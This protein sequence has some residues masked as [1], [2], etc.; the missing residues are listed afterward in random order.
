MSTP[1]ILAVLAL[2][3]PQAEGAG[4]AGA[5]EPRW[6]E[7]GEAPAAL[8]KDYRP[9]LVLYAPESAGAGKRGD[10][11]Q[12][13]LA[14]VARD[15]TLRKH[16]SGFACV[17]LPEA[18]LSKEYPAAPGPAAAAAPAPPAPP[19]AK[20]SVAKRLGLVPGVPALLVIDFREKV[21]RRYESK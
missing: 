17:K 12:G 13:A 20:T 11:P 15:V 19:P 7:L 2:G 16:L 14:E 8:R 5:G 10:P 18:A 3:G 21:A 4:Q 1:F 6:V 9:L